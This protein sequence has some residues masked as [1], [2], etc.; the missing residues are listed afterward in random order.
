MPD[1]HL[2]LTSAELKITHTALRSL[3]SDLG[4]DDRELRDLVRGVL[5]KLPP[6]EEINAID[7]ALRR[8]HTIA[9]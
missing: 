7:L 4:H 8:R 3:L 5:A 9:H 2:E 6:T 1:H